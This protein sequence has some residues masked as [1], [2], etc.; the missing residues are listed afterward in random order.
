MN[1]ERSSTE[2]RRDIERTRAEMD[3]TVDALERRFSPGQLVD[4]AWQLFKREGRG[5]GDIVRDHAVPLALMGLGVAWLAVERATGDSAGDTTRRIRHTAADEPAEGR[6]GPY[7]GDAVNHEDR[8]WE[9]NSPS[10]GDRV[11]DIG[12]SAKDAVRSVTDRAGDALEGAKHA[13]SGAV[14][15]GGEGKDAASGAGERAGEMAD[16]V[17]EGAL[18]RA[19]QAKDMARQRA[20][21]VKHGF[22]DVLDR[23]PLTLGALSFGLGIATGLAV[24]T[25]RWEDERLG[26]TADALKDG[27]R[28]A[29]SDIA[30]E[31]GAVAAETASA[32]RDEVRTDETRS[33]LKDA[34]DRVTH[35]ARDA[36]R[37]TAEERGLT[38]D[39]MTERAREI[40]AR[41]RDAAR[42]DDGPT[43]QGQ[44]HV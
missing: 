2:I 37:H 39:D 7:R 20:G 41:T 28:E 15:A 6:R 34:V 19:H 30:H 1:E 21:Q 5:A 36:A 13:V 40:A 3:E 14:H 18:R 26:R 27:V 22:E 38:G 29:G 32:V 31:V 4:E 23:S 25:T 10:I 11:R 12:H 8:D 16:Q 44:G 43:G 33:G 24:P 35:A 9:H 17:R 42:D